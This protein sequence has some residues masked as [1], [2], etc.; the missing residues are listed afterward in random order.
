MPDTPIFSALIV[1]LPGSHR[2]PL[3]RASGIAL[4][5]LLHLSLLAAVL[6]IPFFVIEVMRPPKAAVRE[7]LIFR[8]P[9][10]SPRGD[11]HPAQAVRKGERDATQRRPAQAAPPA[12]PR[13]A[14][15]PAA[16]LPPTEIPS[17][18][19]TTQATGPDGVPGDPLGT[20]SK[21][22]GPITGNCE[23]DDCT[24][25]GPRVPGDEGPPDGPVYEWDPRITQ[26]ILIPESRALPKYP[27]G[28]RRA[29][30]Q[31]T[32]I[33]LIVIQADGSVGQ[34]E[35]LRSPDQ[36][37]GFDLAALE[38]VKQWR[39]RPGLMD[40]RPVAVQARVIMEFTLSR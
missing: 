24:G 35:V 36:R 29:A 4:A 40:G 22:E 8:P 17:G 11:D 13:P 27:D 31:G 32:V 12:A 7:I 21:S 19:P 16:L 15:A 9:R 18:L 28:A 39:Y 14:E 20:G 23:G 26:P 25:T 3:G 34:V 33:L 1:S 38:A 10:G 2:R 37:W 6:L 30:M 5:L